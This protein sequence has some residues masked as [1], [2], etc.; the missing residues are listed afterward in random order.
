M[1]EGFGGVLYPPRC[2]KEDFSSYVVE[3]SR[4]KFCRLND[5]IVLAMYFNYHRVPIYLYNIPTDEDPYMVGGWMNYSKKDALSEGGHK[6][7]YR[8]AYE[9]ISAYFRDRLQS[10]Q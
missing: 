10:S 2:I 3:T 8:G 5:D 9:F 4:N 1:L 7:N 6:E